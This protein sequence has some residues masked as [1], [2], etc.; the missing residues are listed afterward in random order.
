MPAP[1]LPYSRIVVKGS[2]EPVR[3]ELETVGHE[4]FLE[5]TWRNLGDSGGHARFA[6]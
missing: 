1:L 4:S 6:V 5:Q 3:Q 2:A